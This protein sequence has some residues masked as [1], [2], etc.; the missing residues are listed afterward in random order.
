MD[1]TEHTLNHLFAQLGLPDSDDEV[2]NF[3]DRH[4]PVPASRPVY[5]LDIFTHSQ[6]QFLQEGLQEDAAWAEA[7]DELSSLLRH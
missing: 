6:K 7:I 5:E 2:A 1:T 4:K 3:I